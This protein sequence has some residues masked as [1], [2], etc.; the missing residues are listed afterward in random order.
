MIYAAPLVGAEIEAVTRQ[1]S[2]FLPLAAHPRG[3]EN[4]KRTIDRTKGGD[5]TGRTHAGVRDRNTGP[6]H[7][8][9]LDPVG[10]PTGVPR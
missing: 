3:R 2:R 7:H 1:G 10:A 8:L 9:D 5:P 4:W 6:D